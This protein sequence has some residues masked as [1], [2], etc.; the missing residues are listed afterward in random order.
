MI[1]ED[2]WGGDHGRVGM[3]GIIFQAYAGE[4]DTSRIV[5]SDHGICAGILI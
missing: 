1:D 2:P 4:S 5:F 3:T